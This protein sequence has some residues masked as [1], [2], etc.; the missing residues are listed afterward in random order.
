GYKDHTTHYLGV[1]ARGTDGKKARAARFV[2]V[3]NVGGFHSAVTLPPGTEGT[4]FRLQLLFPPPHPRCQ[5]RCP[6]RGKAS[7]KRR[8]ARL[9]CPAAKAR[10]RARAHNHWGVTGY[11]R[12]GRPSRSP[13]RKL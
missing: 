6:R 9:N 3:A 2:G 13:R 10:R 5:I 4:T 12:A 8:I 11:I 1:R 7:P